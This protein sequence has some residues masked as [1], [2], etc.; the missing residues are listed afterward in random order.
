MAERSERQRSPA[1]DPVVHLEPPP[2]VDDP[3]GSV[4]G[5]KLV[6]RERLTNR[7]HPADGRPGWPSAGEV[8]RTVGEVGD[9]EMARR[10]VAAQVDRN[11]AVEQDPASPGRP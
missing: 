5:D 7:Q 10:P 11:G 2:D 8:T 4:H 9:D 3:T 1:D 6:A